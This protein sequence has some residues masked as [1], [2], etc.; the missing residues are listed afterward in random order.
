MQEKKSKT[1][2]RNCPI[3]HSQGE[4][5]ENCVESIDWI[6][7]VPGYRSYTFFCPTCGTRI[8]NEDLEDLQEELKGLE[9]MDEVPGGWKLLYRELEKSLGRKPETRD[10][11]NLWKD[12]C[13]TP[14]SL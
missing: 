3:C 14:K 9:E 7:Y 13:K 1:I 2:L 11:V 8:V 6:E 10:I 4:I 12:F 5:K